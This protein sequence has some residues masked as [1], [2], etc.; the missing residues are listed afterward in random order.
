[1]AFGVDTAENEPYKFA[2]LAE[3]SEKGSISNLST[4]QRAREQERQPLRAHWPALS[5]AGSAGCFGALS[6]LV[7]SGG[8]TL[9][10]FQIDHA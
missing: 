3:K 10:V 9:I 7:G 5:P 4:K 8:R 2:H 1:M 6:A